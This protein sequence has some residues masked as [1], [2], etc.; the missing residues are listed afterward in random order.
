MAIPSQ[1]SCDFVWHML[2]NVNNVAA[3]TRFGPVLLP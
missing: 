1:S 3:K 2:I